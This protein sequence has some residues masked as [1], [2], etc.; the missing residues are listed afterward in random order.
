MRRL[1]LI[2]LLAALPFALAGQSITIT[3]FHSVKSS[4]DPSCILDQ[5]GQPCAEIRLRTVED[6]WTIDAGLAGIEDVR[7]ADG[8]V[9]LYVPSWATI[10]TVAHPHYRPLRGWIIPQTLVPGGCYTATLGVEWD[11]PL[12]SP[13]TPAAEPFPNE[14]FSRD[15]VDLFIGVDPG[16]ELLSGGLRYTHVSRRIGP[17][18]A[19]GLTDCGE[20]LFLGGAALRLTRPDRSDIDVQVFGG[21]GLAGGYGAVF[22]AGI[23]FG[24][25]TD[26]PLSFWDFGFGC[27]VID[28]QL[29]PTLELGLAIWG[30]PLCLALSMC[31]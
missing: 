22:E 16:L 19:L 20:G 23:R 26:W 15:F 5:E 30:I 12:G 31:L 2:S 3:G 4:P 10:L 13:F 29:V 24:W 17:Y 25:R 21:A 27:Q 14:G 28:H 7:I 18:L 11:K 8:Y 1:I 9:V 6:G